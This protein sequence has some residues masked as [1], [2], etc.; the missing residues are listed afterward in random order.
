MGW[1]CMRD[2]INK[3]SWKDG[4]SLEVGQRIAVR[5]AL[6][7]GKMLGESKL[8][9][10]EHLALCPQDRDYVRS[11]SQRVRMD[12]MTVKRS[13][14]MLEY[15]GLVDSTEESQHFRYTGYHPMERN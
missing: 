3:K 2:D 5:I 7:C 15:L 6:A 1:G 9:I 13:L 10:M 14:E 8:C 4:R 11:I 12:Y